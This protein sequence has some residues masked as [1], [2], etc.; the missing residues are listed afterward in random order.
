MWT[1]SCMSNLQFSF[2]QIKGLIWSTVLYFILFVFSFFFSL[3]FGIC[4]ADVSDCC[5][6]KAN[7]SSEIDLDR[8]FFI[9]VCYWMPNSCSVEIFTIYWSNN[10]LDCYSGKICQ[11]DVGVARTFLFSHSTRLMS[12]CCFSIALFQ[13]SALLRWYLRLAEC[14]GSTTALLAVVL[15]PISFFESIESNRSE[16]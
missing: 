12:F 11:T 15:S 4:F 10:G 1:N 13:S 7:M 14:V 16:K 9:S 2:T 5:C 3:R 8:S 6:W